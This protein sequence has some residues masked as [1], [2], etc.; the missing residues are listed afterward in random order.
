MD[1]DTS[2]RNK[3]IMWMVCGALVGLALLALFYLVAHAI[4]NSFEGMAPVNIMSTN[5]HWL[6]MSPHSF[7]HGGPAGGY[8]GAIDLNPIWEAGNPRRV[9][10]RPHM[11]QAYNARAASRR[12]K[13]L[14]R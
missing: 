10:D 3:K 1:E 6:Y 4:M 12:Q 2:D 13:M 11:A 7:G 14:H 9:Q 5:R 8:A